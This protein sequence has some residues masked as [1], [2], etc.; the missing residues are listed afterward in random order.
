MR[1]LIVEKSQN[2]KTGRTFSTYRTQ[3]TCPTTCPLMGNGCYAENRMGRPS[4][5]DTAERGQI[6]GA[7]YA[8][9]IEKLE[10]LDE[11][12][13]IRFNV[14]GDYLDDAGRPDMP[15]I[16]ATNHARG[17]VLSY[18]HAWR[19]LDPKWF[20]TGALPNAS[21]DTLADVAVAKDAGWPTVIV[22]PQ[23]HGAWDGFG[24]LEGF[25]DCLHDQTGMQCVDC[26]LCA[27]GTRK[28]T[29]VFPVHGTR[30][31]QAATVLKEIA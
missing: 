8:P 5:F 12:A 11:S 2:K 6:I 19:Q 18:T 17:P 10:R 21:C 4:P 22:D 27:R 26:K 28:S 9:L 16:E 13:V 24:H 30:R 7:D 15:Y 31:R 14:A 3:D 20:E 29:V 25:I 1:T 23:E